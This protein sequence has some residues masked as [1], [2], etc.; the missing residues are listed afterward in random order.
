LFITY[1]RLEGDCERP[2][3]LQEG[4]MYNNKM[5]YRSPSNIWIITTILF[6]ILAV[7]AALLA[8]RCAQPLDCKTVYRSEGI[9]YC[10][11]EING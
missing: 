3:S 2:F 10:V 9:T 6:G 11:S 8:L 4:S 5:G 7:G 1:K